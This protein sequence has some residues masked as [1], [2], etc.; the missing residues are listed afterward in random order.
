VSAAD[1]G[2]PSY[3]RQLQSAAVHT[4]FSAFGGMQIYGAEGG[5]TTVMDDV[6]SVRQTQRH[7]DPDGTRYL[8]TTNITIS[9]SKCPLERP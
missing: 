5:P 9:V 6:A 8:Y 3:E 1:W 2:E 7:T 4:V